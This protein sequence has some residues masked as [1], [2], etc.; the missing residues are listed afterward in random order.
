MTADPSRIIATTGS[1]A[2]AVQVH[3]R[4]I[5]ELHP[6]G[7]SPETASENLP[8]VSTRKID[9]VPD[10]HPRVAFPYR[11]VHNPV[12]GADRPS[13]P[14]CGK[15]TYSHG[16]VHPQCSAE[17]EAKAADAALKAGRKSANEQVRQL[18]EQDGS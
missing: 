18:E 10:D 17:R 5:P 15:A 9:G 11:H 4:D 2:D 16:G 8:R 3:H 14:V 12:F 6:D 1:T 7:E 13:C